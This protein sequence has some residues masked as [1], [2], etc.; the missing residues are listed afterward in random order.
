MEYL[1]W[2]KHHQPDILRYMDRFITNDEIGNPTKYFYNGFKKPISSATCRYIKILA[3]LITLFGSLKDLDIV[4]IGG[5]YGG[6]C[7]I[8]YDYDKPKSYTIIDLP[9][10]CA[11]IDKC[12]GHFGIND[13]GI[14]S[15]NS[16]FNDEKYSLCIS[17]YAFS[18]FDRKDQDFYAEKVINHSE[19]GYMLCN[20][21]GKNVV[22]GREDCF[23]KEEIVA[24]KATGN[25][26]PE[27][28]LTTEGN[29]LYI[30]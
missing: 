11:L 17:N 26:L 25:A 28:P 18:E 5:G 16:G 27:E 29:F 4:E 14:K 15:T 12:L 6:Q 10:A 9:E 2:V 24:L 20:F 13:V 1:L 21:F 30:W 3:E 22:L 19:K 23:T 7:K 8:I